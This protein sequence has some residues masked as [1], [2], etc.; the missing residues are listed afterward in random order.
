[1]GLDDASFNHFQVFFFLDEQ[2][3]D[4]VGEFSLL[5]EGLIEMILHFVLRGMSGC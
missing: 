3:V 2:D 4:S 5:F 1:V